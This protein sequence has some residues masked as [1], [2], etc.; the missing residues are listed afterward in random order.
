MVC[1]EMNRLVGKNTFCVV[2]NRNKWNRRKSIE[3]REAKKYENVYDIQHRRHGK[4]VEKIESIWET[5]RF[6]A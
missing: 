3:I 1:I 5:E 6:R 2:E 4:Q